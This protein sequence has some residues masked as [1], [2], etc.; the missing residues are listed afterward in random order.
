MP[1]KEILTDAE[2]CLL[3]Y[4]NKA[5]DHLCL[6]KSSVSEMDIA[7]LTETALSVDGIERYFARSVQVLMEGKSV[8]GKLVALYLMDS[9]MRHTRFRHGDKTVFTSRF[10]RHKAS[11]LKHALI[12]CKRRPKM[13]DEVLKTFFIWYRNSVLSEEDVRA[14][15][16]EVLGDPKSVQEWWTGKVDAFYFKNLDNDATSTPDEMGPVSPNAKS[17]TDRVEPDNEPLLIEDEDEC[18]SF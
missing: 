5:L 10:K 1:Q 8:D 16:A 6:K 11:I 9:L 14:F 3:S 12:Y 17:D 15:A 18:I 13:A 2:E 4:F 7:V